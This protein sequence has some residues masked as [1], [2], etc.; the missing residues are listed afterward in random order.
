MFSILGFLRKAQEDVDKH[1]LAWLE[2]I[3][4]DAPQLA[5]VPPPKPRGIHRRT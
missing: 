5:L 1:T 3:K 4:Q 2:A